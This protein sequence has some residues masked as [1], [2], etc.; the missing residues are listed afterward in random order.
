MLLLLLVSLAPAGAIECPG[1]LTHIDTFEINGTSWSACEDLQVPDGAL[2]LVPERGQPE[3]FPKSYSHYGS[4]HDDDPS[5]YLGLGRHNASSGP[6]DILGIKM[7]DKDTAPGGLSWQ[8]V[9]DAVP[10]LRTTGGA[11]AFV[12]SRGS[13][14]DTTFNDQGED[15]AGYGFPPPRSYVFNLTNLAEGGLPFENTNTQSYINQS[16]MAEGLVGGDLPVVIYYF[17][18]LPACNASKP[19]IHA[20]PHLQAP[21]SQCCK[22]LPTDF[23]AGASRYWTMVA[24]PTPDMAGSREQGVWFRF[25]QIECTGPE[26]APPCK[27][28]GAAQ[29]WDT[30]WWTRTP[31][32]AGDTGIT[33]PTAAADASG[34]YATLL[35]NRRWWSAE[36]AKEGLMEISLPSR[37]TTTNGTWLSIQAH[38]NIILSMITKHDTWGPRYGV[39]PGYG[40]EMQNGFEDVFTSLGMMAVEWGALPYAKG[41]IEN[42][43]SH[44]IRDDGLTKYRAEEVAQQARMLTILA[45]Y[46]AYV[47]VHVGLC[48]RHVSGS[49]ALLVRFAIWTLCS[50][51]F[52]RVV[53]VV[54]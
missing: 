43:F 48:S 16:G 34:F 52:L 37:E 27:Q 19:P 26:M 49:A 8:L 12:G 18:V 36:L 46:H 6:V 13:V 9:A 2:V 39:L 54:C 38:H 51:P 23:P 15:S 1:G 40:I 33:G 20:P 41:L 7:L 17:P 11:R 35:E 31:A 29:Y 14:A 47:S 5:Y 45:L 42:Q 30:Y 21:P 28:I 3:W 50:A 10:P 4:A 32:A 53:F 22:D 24:N 44:Y 25:V